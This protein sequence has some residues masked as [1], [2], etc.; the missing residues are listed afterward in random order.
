MHSMMTCLAF[1]ALATLLACDQ[2]GVCTTELV[3]L[4]I[5]VDMDSIPTEGFTVEAR[6]LDTSE[7]M[8]LS[9]DAEGR[10]SLSEAI[11]GGRVQLQVMHSDFEGDAVD[12]MWACDACH[13]RPDVEHID[14]G[15]GGTVVCP[16]VFMGAHVVVVDG[17][18]RGIKGA[19]VT[20]RRDGEVVCRSEPTDLG[21]EAFVSNCGAGTVMV[22][23]EHEGRSGPSAA[24]EWT[25]HLCG[26]SAAD[27]TLT[28]E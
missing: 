19:V 7:R 25:C 18:G 6:N 16:G 9:L 17:A 21:G 15:L 12:V 10:T 20:G 24:S 22:S 4:A 26:C 1:A 8:S 13:C 11:G 3:T 5:R 28:L 14:L 27:L 23:A 2:G